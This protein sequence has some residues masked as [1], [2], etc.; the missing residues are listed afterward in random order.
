MNTFKLSAATVLGLSL[1][2]PPA[3]A[4]GGGSADTTTAPTRRMNVADKRLPI[5]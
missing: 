4:A 5:A 2:V 1:M 3:G